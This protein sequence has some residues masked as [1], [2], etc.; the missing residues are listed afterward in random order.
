M[1]DMKTRFLAIKCSF[2]GAKFEFVY[3]LKTAQQ[4][5][6]GSGCATPKENINKISAVD[7]DDFFGFLLTVLSFWDTGPFPADTSK[8]SLGGA[9]RWDQQ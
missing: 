4:S 3:F 6:K 5:E 7:E 8:V 1:L 9:D 2:F